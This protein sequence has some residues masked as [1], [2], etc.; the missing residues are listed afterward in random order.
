MRRVSA[1]PAIRSVS[2]S[3]YCYCVTV[4]STMI[5]LVAGGRGA[6]QEERAPLVS[7]IIITITI[8]V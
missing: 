3:C 6:R 2:V 8:V 7:G 4:T 5:A 1:A